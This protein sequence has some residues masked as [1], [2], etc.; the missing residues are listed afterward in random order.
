PEW[1]VVT[2]LVLMA[3][4]EMTIGLDTVHSGFWVPFYLV[5]AFRW[6]YAIWMMLAFSVL[7][8]CLAACLDILLRAQVITTYTVSVAVAAAIGWMNESGTIRLREEIG[9]DPRTG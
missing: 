8:L 6:Q 3:L 1:L 5:F 2:L 7:F 4:R 9:A